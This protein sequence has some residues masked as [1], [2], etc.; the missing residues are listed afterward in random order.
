MSIKTAFKKRVKKPHQGEVKSIAGFL[1]A[2]ERVSK[3]L[4]TIQ[5]E[6]WVGGLS[7]EGSFK[8]PHG[9]SERNSQL[10]TLTGPTDCSEQ[11]CP[12][13]PFLLSNPGGI[14]NLVRSEGRRTGEER[15]M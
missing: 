1:R 3:K 7:N 11:D 8:R 6:F 13:P 14:R 10:E 4:E 5:R 12:S 15:R 2:A 9:I